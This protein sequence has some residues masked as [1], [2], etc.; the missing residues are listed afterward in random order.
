M[1]YFKHPKGVRDKYWLLKSILIMKLT[2]ILI[3]TFTLQSVANVYSQQKVTINLKSADFTKVI[4]AIQKQTNY[5]FVFSERKLS[6]TKKISINVENKDV[7][8]VLTRLL[9]GT[10]LKFTQLENDLIVITNKNEIVNAAVITGNVV[11]ENE[12][13]TVARF[14]EWVRPDISKSASVLLSIA[15]YKSIA[16]S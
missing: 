8:E 15:L 6:A 13:I 2:L 12:F 9:E 14:F 1:E 11:D 3:V 7:S 16:P 10:D 4:A 5:H